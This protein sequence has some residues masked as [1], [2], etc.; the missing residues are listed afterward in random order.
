MSSENAPNAL[1]SSPV[2]RAKLE[3]CLADGEPS[4]AK[5]FLTGISCQSLKTVAN[6]FL[7]DILHLTPIYVL[8]Y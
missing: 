5:R 1:T 4:L 8:F 2:R 7:E 6:C 3:Q